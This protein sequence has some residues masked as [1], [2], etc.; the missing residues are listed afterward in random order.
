MLQ[1]AQT[2]LQGGHCAIYMLSQI[3][4][5]LDSSLTRHH[6]VCSVILISV[7]LEFKDGVRMA[8]DRVI[9]C[10]Y[11]IQGNTVLNIIHD[12]KV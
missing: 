1:I 3:V 2:S 11:Y 4:H 9:L 8:S 10:N 7:W 5:Y 6:F 12:G